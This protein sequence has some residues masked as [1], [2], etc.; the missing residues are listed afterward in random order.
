MPGRGW[1]GRAPVSSA[2]PRR[3][4]REERRGEGVRATTM[5]ETEWAACDDGPLM[6]TAAGGAASDRKLRLLACASARLAWSVMP[7]KGPWAARVLH[8]VGAAERFADGLVEADALLSACA[9]L[10]HCLE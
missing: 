10:Q 8:A 4:G 5:T 7:R 3:V 6:L 9:A 2:A 1:S